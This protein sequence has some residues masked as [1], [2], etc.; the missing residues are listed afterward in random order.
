MELCSIVHK[1]DCLYSITL[2]TTFSSLQYILAKPWITGA[3]PYIC[4]RTL[5]FITY[6]KIHPLK[7]TWLKG[8]VKFLHTR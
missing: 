2:S 4:Q 8:K 5:K 1:K 6:A 3:N 7:S